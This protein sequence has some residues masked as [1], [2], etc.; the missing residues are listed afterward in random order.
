M[1]IG[2]LYTHYY[3]QLDLWTKHPP[4]LDY[5]SNLS[6]LGYLFLKSNRLYLLDDFNE[7]LKL[8]KMN[9]LLFFF[10]LMVL[11][12]CQKKQYRD[13]T[14]I[15]KNPITI[16]Y[17]DSLSFELDKIYN[18]GFIN[19]FSVAVVGKDKTLYEGGFGYS[20]VMT[21][22]VYSIH[23]I[24]NIASI[25][26]T[27]L[28]ISLLKAQELGMLK[29]DDDINN[30]LPFKVV[31]PYYVDEKITIRHLATHTSSI[32]DTEFYGNKSYVLKDE[33]DK[34]EKA[35][36]LYVELNPPDSYISM[37][38]YLKKVLTKKGEW[39]LKNGFLNKKPG[40]MFEYSNVATT[41]A[42][43]VLE[44]ATG[45]HY[46]DFSKR[47]ILTPLKMQSTGWSFEAIDMSKH[48]KL[49]QNQSKEIPL[50]SLIT[51]PDGGLLTSSSDLAKYLK[52]LIKGFSGNGQL[53]TEESYKEFF[54]K[55]LSPTNFRE[56]HGENEGIFLSFSS[57][58]N[59][60]HSGGDPG[61]ATY[62]FF[63]PVSKLG[64]ILFVNT[65][66]SK[67]GEKEYNLI[68]TKLDE[69]GNNL[70]PN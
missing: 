56:N 16:N 21:E 27:F 57:N 66:L 61:V 11:L 13:T 43:L 65:D 15:D 70:K 17:S 7:F 3:I 64:I 24:Q 6:E 40:T 38:E 1:N 12:S 9:K 4:H 22:K 63:N 8:V 62:M 18:Q 37:T 42:A 19:G 68:L 53:L 41:L 49:Y 60:G 34:S 31:N 51:Y 54:T 23:T 28:G 20:N 2:I 35:T 58:G 39:Y 47:H 36:K 25:S 67:E 33:K 30:Y 26:K 14:E 46:D 44:S 48:T 32:V 5:I 45:M 50:Y 59:I 29:L 52:E 55:Q 69:F 10:S